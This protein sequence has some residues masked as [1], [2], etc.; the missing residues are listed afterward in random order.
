MHSITYSLPA[1][2]PRAILAALG[3]LA[4]LTL[5]APR[6]EAGFV[7]PDFR[8]APDTTFFGW[9][10]FEQTPDKAFPLN[11][12]LL[13]ETPDIGSNPGGALVKQ[14]NDTPFTHWGN[15]SATNNLYSGP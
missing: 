1:L 9:D 15:I 13:D 11:F 5:I 4:T 8:G 12:Y 14:N 7:T 6:A 2:S 10:F 3:T